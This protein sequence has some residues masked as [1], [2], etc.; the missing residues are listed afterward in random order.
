MR[1]RLLILVHHVVLIGKIL[2][3]LK[4]SILKSRIKIYKTRR[5]KYEQ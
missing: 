2:Y 1:V 3:W 5:Y 4:K